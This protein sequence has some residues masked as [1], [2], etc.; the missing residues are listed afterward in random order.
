M[1]PVRSFPLIV[2]LAACQSGP[3]AAV[4]ITSGFTDHV[5]RLSPATGDIL[6]S[7][8]VNPRA[9]E[10]DEPHGV[11]AAADG[12]DGYATFSHGE[13]TLW[14]FVLPS[15][16]LVG[17]LPLGLAGASRIGI[18]P[19]GNRA[20]IP[21]YYRSEPGRPGEVAV[22]RLFD[23]TV[24]DRVTVCPAPH[25]AGVNPSGT[26]V[27]VTCSMSDEIV[28][29][30]AATLDQISRFFVD[31]SPGPAGEPRHRPLNA[32]WS[33]D[34]AWLFVTLHQAGLV[35]AFT[36]DGVPGASVMVGDGPAQLAVTADGATI[37]TANRLDGSV[38]LIDA[39]GFLERARI[40]IGESFPHGV[41]VAADGSTAFVTFEGSTT[42]PGGAVGIDLAEDRILWKTTAGSATLGVAY[43]EHGVRRGGS[44][45]GSR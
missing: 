25:H 45:D 9:H 24:T 38:S 3:D 18:T 4:Y 11:A 35:R 10:T 22:V 36:P 27:A 32:A 31:E 23:L 28:V 12:A 39:A 6:D 30:D 34:G 40:P 41:A 37:I 21:D 19:D 7:I 14:K 42:T 20:F 33:P 15:N 1:K 26:M 29:L 44:R 5:F 16:R 43:V 13:P 17:M 8:A 2:L